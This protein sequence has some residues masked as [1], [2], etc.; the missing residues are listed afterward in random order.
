VE[1]PTL[2]NNFKCGHC[3]RYFDPETLRKQPA[4]GSCHHYLGTPEHI[5]EKGH[6]CPTQGGSKYV[7]TSLVHCPTQHSKAHKKEASSKKRKLSSQTRFFSQD[8][9]KSMEVAGLTDDDRQGFLTDYTDTVRKRRCDLTPQRQSIAD[10]WHQEVAKELALEKQKQAEEDQ[11]A[12][13]KAEEAKE[14]EAV[15]ELEWHEEVA[16]GIVAAREV[17]KMSE[18]TKQKAG[19]GGELTPTETVVLQD[20]EKAQPSLRQKKR[21]AAKSSSSDSDGEESS[22]SREEAPKGITIRQLASTILDQK[23]KEQDRLLRKKKL[24]NLELKIIFTSIE[25]HDLSDE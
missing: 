7:C 3:Y 21:V 18:S 22:S 14:R 20:A 13:E 4:C 5:S 16:R 15:Q 11:K 19:E 23:I 2:P 1:N 25:E 6:S 8:L 10:R 12:R 17:E 9:G 24:I